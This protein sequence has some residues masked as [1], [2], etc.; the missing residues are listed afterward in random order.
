MERLEST[1]SQPD[2]VAQ[3]PAGC[4]VYFCWGPGV[5]SDYGYEVY[6]DS[7]DTTHLEPLG[8]ELGR[9]TTHSD[10]L[11]D[12]VSEGPYVYASMWELSTINNRMAGQALEVVGVSLQICRAAIGR[13][14]HHQRE[15]LRGTLCPRRVSCVAYSY[16]TYEPRL[17]IPSLR[18]TPQTFCWS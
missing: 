3:I 12:S 17:S 16:Y 11:S 5:V 1:C 9:W 7:C 8:D 6:L 15:R 13:L 14:D 18:D 4:T 2:M 10:A